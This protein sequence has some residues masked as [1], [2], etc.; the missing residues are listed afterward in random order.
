MLYQF[1]SKSKSTLLSIARKIDTPLLTPN[2][3]TLLSIP[4]AII[5][6]YFIF[7]NN[8]LVAIAFVAIS[9]F[10]DALDGALATI[11][12]Q[13]TPFGNYLDSV[14]DRIVE[15]VI[16]LGFIMQ[17][18]FATVLAFSLGIIGTH[19]KALV[20]EVVEADNRDWPGLGGRPD[21]AILLIVGM[22]IAAFVPQI[23]SLFT[24]ELFLYL[25]ALIVLVGNVQRI[26]FA[27]VVLQNGG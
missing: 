3:L 16:Y 27:R 24:V 18:P 23:N 17:F 15:A 2:R 11:R 12:N 21:R 25:I 14:A 8:Y 13:K 20:G 26:L 9:F 4:F 5:A 6:A 10:I 1:R 19:T 22:V 7:Y